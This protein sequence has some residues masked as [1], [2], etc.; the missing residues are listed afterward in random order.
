MTPA[1]SRPGLSS[2]ATAAATSRAANWLARSGAASGPDG[3]GVRKGARRAQRAPP[4]QP[5]N[6]SSVLGGNVTAEESGDEETGKSGSA[7]RVRVE[8]E[9]KVDPCESRRLV[10]LRGLNAADHAWVCYSASFY[11]GYERQ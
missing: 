7:D 3:G 9:Y 5:P 2:A 6:H 4:S 8:R 10:K 1:L 11:V